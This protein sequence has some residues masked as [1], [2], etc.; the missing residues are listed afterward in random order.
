VTDVLGAHKG[1]RSGQGEAMGV[2]DPEK[3]ERAIVCENRAEGK[4]FKRGPGLELRL[5]EGSSKGK[6]RGKESPLERRLSAGE[7]NG[8][9]GLKNKTGTRE[10]KKRSTKYGI[11]EPAEP[12]NRKNGQSKKGKG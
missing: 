12:I 4:M 6:N 7:K 8:S 3:S 1:E 10:R 2:L 9:K 11:N 5:A